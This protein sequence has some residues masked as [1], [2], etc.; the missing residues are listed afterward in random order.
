MLT[1]RTQ[2]CWLHP[3][4][5]QSCAIYVV[6]AQ[7]PVCQTAAECAEFRLRPSGVDV[8]P[9]LSGRKCLQGSCTMPVLQLM[10]HCLL[11]AAVFMAHNMLRNQPFL[12]PTHAYTQVNTHTKAHIH[13]HTFKHRGR[14]Y[15]SLLLTVAAHSC[16]VIDAPVKA[17]F[18]TCGSCPP[19]LLGLWKDA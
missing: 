10:L 6:I 8:L 16:Y 9:V 5:S 11:D 17:G 14:S 7:I 1:T 2:V 18:Q 4:S 13:A 19:G 3:D 15:R 12:P